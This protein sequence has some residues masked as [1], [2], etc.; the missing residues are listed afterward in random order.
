MS[1]VHR[2][3]ESIGE[4]VWLDIDGIES[5]SQFEEKI[6]SA[7]DRSEV[8]LYMLS[9]SSMA[10]EWTKREVL[11]AE[12]EGKH[13]IP[14]LLDDNKFKG[15][16][17]FHFGNIDFVL[18]DNQEHF[19]RLVCSICSRLNITP[20]VSYN[21]DALNYLCQYIDH[22]KMGFKSTFDNRVYITPQFDYAE[23][24]YEGISRVQNG[25]KYGYVDKTG[26]IIAPCIYPIARRFNDGMAWVGRIVRTRISKTILGDLT[27]HDYEYGA[28]SAKGE[29]VVPFKEYK[30]APEDFSEGLAAVYNE[31]KMCGFI[32]K[33]GMIVIPCQYK[34][35]LTD[36]KYFECG[37]ALVCNP[38]CSEYYLLDKEGNVKVKLRKEVVA[39]RIG[40]NARGEG[41]I[42]F[43][44]GG[45]YGFI[46]I[47]EK[48][49][50]VQPLY[51]TIS[52]FVDGFAQVGKTWDEQGFINKNGD[53]VIPL[54]YQQVNSFSEGLAWVKLHNKCMAI[55]K[56]GKIIIDGKFDDAF[57]F[58]DGVSKVGIGESK[59]RQYGII[60][61]DANMI[62]PCSYDGIDGSFWGDVMWAQKNGKYG[63]IDKY[64]RVVIPFV[65]E[66]NWNIRRE[67]KLF[68]AKRGNETICVDIWGNTMKYV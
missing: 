50:V 29:I 16:F 63:A 17:K 5:G 47:F 59:T 48:K 19:R 10:S 23:N 35:G 7:I 32:D 20:L 31:D 58:H 37:S 42:G 21:N 22:D 51:T 13:I 43:S 68:Y 25:N 33:Q 1:F 26:K 4:R 15:W 66:R 9:E 3:E 65:Y 28:I 64:N 45:K 27:I 18:Y 24:F 11:Y 56:R 60:G 52:N 46:N 8:F 67:A 38:S 61:K 30:E 39:G 44:Q 57:S 36:K 53:V 55:D 62:I 54:I 41:M 14:I 12:S 49:I 6:V 34:F 40:N 2:L